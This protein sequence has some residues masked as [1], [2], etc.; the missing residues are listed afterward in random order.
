[1][2]INRLC[3]MALALIVTGC[4]EV[5]PDTPSIHDTK[6]RVIEAGACVED[7]ATE[8]M[9]E[10]KTDAPGL[11]D[12]RNTYTWFNPNE[13]NNE[14]DYRGTPN[15]GACAGS[16]CDTWAIVNAV[17]DAGH[18]GFND[19]RMPSRDELMSISDLS[20]AG[21]PPTANVEVFPYMQAAEY[22][23]GYD[24]GSQ[25]QSAWAWNFHYGHDRVDWKAIP[26]FVRLVRGTAE[27]LDKVK[28]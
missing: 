17:N 14:L 20:K 21:D 15:G 10:T 13:A 18:C 5:D 16:T 6:Y 11:H 9:W 4:A 8:L 3:C 27:N 19:W 22:W 2:T 12:W 25:Y 23:T 28:E 1:M 24:Y 7:T 26:K